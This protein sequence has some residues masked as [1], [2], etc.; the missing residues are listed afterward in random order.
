[1]KYHTLWYICIYIYIYIYMYMYISGL[2]SSGVPTVHVLTARVKP[3]SGTSSTRPQEV[4][5]SSGGSSTR[6]HVNGEIIGG[7][8][9]GGVGDGLP[10]VNILTARVKPLKGDMNEDVTKRASSSNSSTYGRADSSSNGGGVPAV[11][12]LSARTK[13]KEGITKGGDLICI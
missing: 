13:P 1:M 4:S 12:I 3:S 10:A 8:S 2:D 7:T 11:N 6:P 9:N 5:G